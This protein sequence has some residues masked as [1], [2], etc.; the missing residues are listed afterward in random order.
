MDLNKEKEIIQRAK[1]DPEVFGVIFDEYYKPIFGFVLKRLGN[2]EASQDVVS[3]G[4]SC[5]R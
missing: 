5:G 2:V 1:K 4:L 3:N